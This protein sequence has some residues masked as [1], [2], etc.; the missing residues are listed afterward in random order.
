MSAPGPTTGRWLGRAIGLAWVGA[1]LSLMAHGGWQWEGAGAW[2]FGAPDTNALEAHGAPIPVQVRAGQW[3]RVLLSAWLHRSLIGLVLLLWFQASMSRQLAPRAGAARTW[4]VFFASGAC[5]AVAQVLTHPDS[6]HPG[7]AGPFDAV[8]GCLGALLVWGLGNRGPDARS[9][10][11]SA[12]ASTILVGIITA[13]VVMETGDDPRVE[14]VLGLESTLAGF[15]AG[16][17]AMLLFGPRRCARP[18]GTATK[19]LAWLAGAALVAAAAVQALAGGASSDETLRALERLE[20]VEYE[21]WWISRHP[22][23]VT[24]ERR[25][26]LA[27][28]LAAVRDDPVFG[29]GEGATALGAYLHALRAYTGAVPRPWETEARNQAAFRAWLPYEQALRDG[30]ALPARDRARHF[31]EPR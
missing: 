6:A 3:Q 24:D 20:Q 22:R 5:G 13:V 4:I 12:L 23:E 21:A 15:G 27:E 19:A 10:F 28:R 31:W 16:A 17:L 25:A 1:Y 18:A 14:A 26:R 9:V 11:R 29:N 30:L 2:G 8:A 7:G